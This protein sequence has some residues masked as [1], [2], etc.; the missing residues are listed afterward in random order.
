VYR[1]FPK[2][3]EEWREDAFL[4][5]VSFSPVCNT[6]KAG[7]QICFLY[8]KAYGL[9][10]ASLR[11]GHVY[12]PEA[13]HVHDPIKTMTENAA[14]GKPSDLSHVPADTRAHTVYAKD[15]GEITCLV[16]LA[17]TLKHSIY[18]ISDGGDPGM[19]EVSRVIEEIIPA[20]E[21]RLG[22]ETGQSIYSGVTMDRFKEE[23]GYAPRLLREGIAAYIDWLKKEIY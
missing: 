23:F 7:E 12:G 5:P 4:P 1:G 13:T 18:N 15:V 2:D 8:A 22:P 6:K 19:K 21:I 9:S 14:S 20:A 11:V 17:Q 16:H 3:C 10:I